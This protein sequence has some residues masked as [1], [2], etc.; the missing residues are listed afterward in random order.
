[1]ADPIT[2][3]TLATGLVLGTG[4]AISG[5]A[6]SEGYGVIKRG[7]DYIE[8]KAKEEWDWLA[9]NPSADDLLKQSQKAD[10]DKRLSNLKQLLNKYNTPAEQTFNNYPIISGKKKVKSKK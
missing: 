5:L 1:M 2:F 6:V 8:D 4:F 9:G 7:L 10:A 3:G